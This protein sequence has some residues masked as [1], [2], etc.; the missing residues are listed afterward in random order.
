MAAEMPIAFAFDSVALLAKA[1][2]VVQYSRGDRPS[3]VRGF[4]LSKNILAAT[5]DEIC[6]HDAPLWRRLELFVEKQRQWKTPFVAAGERLVERLKN[7]DLG[8]GAP[9]IGETM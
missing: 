7:G 6:Q 4:A 2:L 3:A 8:H 1:Q 9:Q 5:L